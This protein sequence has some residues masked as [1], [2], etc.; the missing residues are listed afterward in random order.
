MSEQ[1]FAQGSVKPTSNVH[2]ILPA[3]SV[4]DRQKP[5]FEVGFAI[6]AEQVAA[7]QRL[8]AE[9]FGEEYGIDCS[10]TGG[11]DI[12]AYD[13]FCQHINV[14]DVANNN[15][16]IATTRLLSDESAKLAGGFYSAQ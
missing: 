16:I 8:R 9:T 4:A 12:D 7:A 3:A 14:Y 5:R 11:L 6:T 1:I 2:S 13:A 15:Q 10:A